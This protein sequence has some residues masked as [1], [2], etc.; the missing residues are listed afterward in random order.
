MKFTSPTL[1]FSTI[2]AAVA[3]L[4]CSVGCKHQTD[5]TAATQKR[6]REFTKKIAANPGGTKDLLT[7]ADREFLYKALYD[8]TDEECSAAL[9]LCAIAYRVPEEKRRLLEH[10]IPL[11]DSADVTL[12]HS[13]FWIIQLLKFRNHDAKLPGI[14][15]KLKSTQLDTSRKVLFRDD[16]E[17]YLIASAK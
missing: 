16:L 11:L 12:N 15:A 7:D 10:I 5:G 3:I 13:G 6:A 4:L 8:A 1:V 17:A 9:T 2:G 14:L